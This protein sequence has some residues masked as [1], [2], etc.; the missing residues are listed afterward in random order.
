MAGCR[1]PP[2]R[3]RWAARPWLGWA[4]GLAGAIGALIVALLDKRGLY[5]QPILF[6]AAGYFAFVLFRSWSQRRT[7]RREASELRGQAAWLEQRTNLARELH[8]VVG[9][10]VTAMVVQAEAGQLSDDPAAA[11]R[12]IADTGRTALGELDTL[13]THLRDPDATVTVSAP[14]RLSDIDELL[15]APLRQFGLAVLV[16]LDPAPGLDELGTLTVYRITQEALTNIARHAGATAAW[17][18]LVRIGDRV[19]LRVSD[20]GSGPPRLPTR[21]SG[22]LGI[23]ERVRACAGTWELS[24]RPG[25]GTT[26]EV[27]LPAGPS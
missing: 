1:W 23:Q 2:R 7:L 3:A 11:M 25:G 26:L 16:Q 13:V 27:S 10:H 12:T 8:D 22:L 20:D 19:R 9:H 21:G 4:L 18:E 14:P 6:V 15:A 17:V 24:N 5:G